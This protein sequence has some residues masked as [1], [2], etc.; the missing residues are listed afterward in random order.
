[1]SLRNSAGVRRL[2]LR[3]QK[4]CDAT[5]WPASA[6][7]RTSAGYLRAT[8]PTVK[9]VASVS[10]RARRSRSTPTFRSTRDSCRSQSARSTSPSN[11]ETWKCSSTS[12]VKKWT[13]RVM[14][15]IVPE[16]N[17]PHAA[18][19]P[20]FERPML[21]LSV[22]MPCFNGAGYLADAIASVRAQTR[23]VR[24]ILVVD[25]GST[26]GSA[27]LAASLGA[28]VLRTAGREGPAAARNLGI[29]EASGDA[30]GFVD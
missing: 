15:D 12:I 29:R 8:Q 2:T 26:D 19:H 27:E 9:K 13:G 30:L 17:P 1:M 18:R 24:E 11:A 4:L 6:L 20:P 16:A 5:S 28:R 25:D 22:V 7:R 21:S 23:P 14:L 10:W 3:C